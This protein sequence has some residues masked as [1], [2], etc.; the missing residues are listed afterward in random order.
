[1]KVSKKYLKAIADIERDH[2][3]CDSNTCDIS[4][5][6]RHGYDL[7]AIDSWD[8]SGAAS[9]DWNPPKYTNKELREQCEEMG[10]LVPHVDCPHCNAVLWCPEET[11][12]YCDSCGNDVPHKET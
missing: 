3:G 10:K 12:Y 4:V 5:A 7:V 1:M 8:G 11:D 2:G 9:S 6:L